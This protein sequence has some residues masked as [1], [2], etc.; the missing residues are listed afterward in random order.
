[1]HRLRAWAG[2]VEAVVLALKGDRALAG[3]HQPDHLDRLLQRI[4]RLFRTPVG[5]AHPGD[6]VGDGSRSQAKLETA[7]TQHVK[8]R[9]RLR[10]HRG[11]AQRKVGDVGEEG[12]AVGLG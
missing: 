5:A 1:V 6:L 4:H 10:H 12:D 8:G 9:G 3:P 2:V 7:A 11:R